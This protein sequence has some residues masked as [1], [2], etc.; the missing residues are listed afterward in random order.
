MRQMPMTHYVSVLADYSLALHTACPL[1]QG[2]GFHRV[3]GD[4]GGLD[5]SPG[6]HGRESP[7]DFQPSP[8][9]HSPSA[10]DAP[11]PALSP[12]AAGEGQSLT[13]TEA[14][15]HRGGTEAA[16]QEAGREEVTEHSTPPSRPTSLPEVS[17]SSMQSPT[18]CC[19]L[20]VN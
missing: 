6:G 8:S 18:F 9:L 7:N 2:D 3:N 4:V 11:S 13:S 12:H 17:Q 14:S 10:A 15:G 20:S 5:A 1:L 19:S 16:R